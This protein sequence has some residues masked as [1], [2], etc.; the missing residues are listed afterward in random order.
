VVEALER[1]QARSTFLHALDQPER[2]V[3]L[4]AAYPAGALGAALAGRQETQPGEGR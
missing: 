2:V 1:Q 4:P 3:V